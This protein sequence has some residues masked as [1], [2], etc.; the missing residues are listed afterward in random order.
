MKTKK[1]I[2]ES[3][4]HAR[5]HLTETNNVCAST[6]RGRSLSENE[7]KWI[8]RNS[9]RWGCCFFPLSQLETMTKVYTRAWTLTAHKTAKIGE[10]AAGDAKCIIMHG[11]RKQAKPQS[12]S[13]KSATQ[14]H[15]LT[16]E[17]A[18]AFTLIQPTMETAATA[19]KTNF[20]FR[21]CS[22]V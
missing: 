7:E 18:I 13:I 9:L 20:F 3:I 1:K 21:F 14:K 4:A 10:S 5:A 2:R 8:T 16:G 12:V 6:H 11:H 17:H 15:S 22:N 19:D